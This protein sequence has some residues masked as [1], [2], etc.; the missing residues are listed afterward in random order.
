VRFQYLFMRPDGA[1]LAELATWIDEGRLRP[2]IH[3]TDRFDEIKDAFA[4]LERGRARG[5]IV[6]SIPGIVP[7]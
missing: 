2:L 5:K 6:I 3:R 4:E 1:Q 7:P